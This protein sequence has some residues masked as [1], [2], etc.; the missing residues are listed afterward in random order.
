M[1]R[2]TFIKIFIATGVLGITGGLKILAG[3]TPV[4]K[5][6]YAVKLKKYPGKVKPLGKLTEGKDLLG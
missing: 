4:Q 2:R 1:K 3:S 5:I 6:P